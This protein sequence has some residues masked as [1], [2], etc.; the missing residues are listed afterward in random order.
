MNLDA[1]HGL[2]LPRW[3][4]AVIAMIEKSP[5]NFLLHKLRRIALLPSDF[6]LV[7]GEIVGRRLVWKAEALKALHND[8]WGS[9]KG[10]SA[11]D[12]TFCKEL[13]YMIARLSLTP[14]ATFDNDARACYNQIIM[15][16]AILL[17]RRLGLPEVTAAWMAKVHWM[18]ENFPK[19]GYG[20]ATEFFGN[21]DGTNTPKHGPN[22]GNRSGPAFWLFIC[23]FLFE[24][25]ESTATGVYFR[26]PT[27]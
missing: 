26:S 22:Q 10:R 16:V 4:T 11:P 2:T 12:A 14:L 23:S 7:M 6:N 24:R 3:K 25:L 21:T 20:T 9:R 13:T 5:G 27:G 19:T 17:A 8:L 18:V 15:K 1:T